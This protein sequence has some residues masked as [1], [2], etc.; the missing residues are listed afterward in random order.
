MSTEEDPIDQDTLAAQFTREGCAICDLYLSS[1]RQVYEE[2]KRDNDAAKM[3]RGH[4]SMVAIRQ[5]RSHFE[6]GTSYRP[7]PTEFF[8][9]VDFAAHRF[10]LPQKWLR[11]QVDAGTI[12]H[13]RVGKTIYFY[14]PLLKSAL[15]RMVQDGQHKERTQ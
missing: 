9:G 6:A 13:L 1:W 15:I 11:G 8:I 4:A 10:R 2:G 7:Q 12:P 3:A 5:V 14:L